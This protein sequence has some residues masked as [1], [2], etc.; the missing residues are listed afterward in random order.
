MK[1][2]EVL[3]ESDEKTLMQKFYSPERLAFEIT[4][5][6]L[7]DS[8]LVGHPDLQPEHIG[9]IMGRSPNISTRAAALMHPNADSTN[10]HHAL[11]SNSKVLRFIALNHPN[12]TSE[13]HEIG[14]S[15]KDPSIRARAE[16]LLGRK[17]DVRPTSYVNGFGFWSVLP[18]LNK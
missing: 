16:Q 1:F 2:S 13:H 5:D 8:F 12:A 11:K 17:A 3:L 14:L 9:L 7:K 4:R 10:L 15:D 18:E 6:P